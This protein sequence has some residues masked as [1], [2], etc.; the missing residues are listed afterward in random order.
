MEVPLSPQ[1]RAPFVLWHWHVWGIRALAAQGKT[2]EAMGNVAAV[3]ARIRQVVVQG[4][5]A[6]FVAQVLG[7][8]LG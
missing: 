1:Q 8:V 4:G 2:A 6:S 3:K 5:P 7:R